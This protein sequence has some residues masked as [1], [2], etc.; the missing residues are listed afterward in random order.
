MQKHMRE[1]ALETF[2]NMLLYSKK[3]V[4]LKNNNDRRENKNNDKNRRSDSSI[5]DRANKFVNISKS[6]KVYRMPLRYLVDVG[7]VNFS[8]SFNTVFI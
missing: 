5:A 6:R 4:V 3:A 8:E 1:K 2:Q 7:L